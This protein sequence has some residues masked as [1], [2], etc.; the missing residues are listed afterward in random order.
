[1]N[2]KIVGIFVAML[3]IVT[4]TITV[5]G[6]MDNRLLRDDFDLQVIQDHSDDVATKFSNPKTQNSAVGIL[7]LIIDMFN[8]VIDAIYINTFYRADNFI[9]GPLL[10]TKWEQE[11]EFNRFTPVNESPNAGYNWRLGCWSTALAQILYYHRSQPYGHVY[12]EL[13]TDC[14]CEEYN[15]ID[16]SLNYYFDW[17]VFLDELHSSYPEESRVEVALYCYYVSLVVQKLFGTG[18]YSLL[19]YDRS[20]A[21]EDHFEKV[22]TGFSSTD[23]EHVDIDDIK[24]MVIKEVMNGRPVMMHLHRIAGGWH[25][26]V[27]DG[28]GKFN[29]RYT[30][31]IN[32]GDGTD[33]FWTD[34]FYHIAQYDNTTYRKIIT[35]TPERKTIIG[36]RVG[37][38]LTVNTLFREVG[39]IDP[40]EFLQYIPEGELGSAWLFKKIEP[41]IIEEGYIPLDMGE[42]EYQQ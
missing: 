29:G 25:A 18:T 42:S 8:R 20:V 34:N 37:P 40:E 17:S 23:F 32:S 4:T 38:Y 9:I 15:P 12:Y 39:L 21:I 30:F 22:V 10:S 13:T 41:P 6:N 33:G 2:K 31:H 24:D 26:V 27:C 11:G 7:G 19:H 28:V 5:V 36:G 35:I 3:L 14:H 1:M 16:K